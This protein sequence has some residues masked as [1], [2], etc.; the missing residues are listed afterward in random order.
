MSNNRYG[1]IYKTTN[2]VTKKV[3]IGQTI[4]INNVLEK[5]YKG[6]GSYLW[7]SI[8]KYGWEKFN[9]D[10]L[11]YCDSKEE[12]NKMEEF[13]IKE[14]NSLYPLGYNLMTGGSQN[15]K[16]H[17]ESRKKM[18]QPGEKNPFYGKKHSEETLCKLRGRKFSKKHKEGI[19]KS[20]K[21]KS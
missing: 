9:S 5:K 19:S 11:C 4:Y 1:C 12:L 14:L 20:K 2:I 15:G 7:N 10:I 21:R 8:N 13:Y 17:E 16:H 3:Y 18:S 6:S